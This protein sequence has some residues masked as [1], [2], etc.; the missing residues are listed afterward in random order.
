MAGLQARSGKLVPRIRHL[1]GRGSNPRQVVHDAA[2]DFGSAKNPEE[3]AGGCK[4]ALDT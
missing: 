1:A 4:Q 3:G 2:N